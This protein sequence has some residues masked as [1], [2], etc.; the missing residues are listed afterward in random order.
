MQTLLLER[1]DLEK[2]VKNMFQELE[3]MESQQNKEKEDFEEAKEEMEGQEKAVNVLGEA[4]KDHKEGTLLQAFLKV[5][6]SALLRL[7][8]P[9]TQSSWE[10]VSSARVMLSS[11]AGCWQVKSQS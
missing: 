11:C 2:D 3:A 9:S 4:T 8:L 5:L 6:L 10:N 7:R 1:V